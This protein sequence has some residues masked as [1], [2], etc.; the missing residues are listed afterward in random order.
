VKK[1]MCF[2]TNSK[3]ASEVSNSLE[4]AFEDL[5]NYANS[6][7]KDC[8]FFEVIAIPVEMKII[9]KQVPVKAKSA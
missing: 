2:D 1:Y 3:Y 6:D 9:Q 5:T 7:L 4:E 8:E